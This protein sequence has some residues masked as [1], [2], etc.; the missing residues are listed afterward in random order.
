MIM[1][2]QGRYVR[3]QLHARWVYS[4]ANLWLDNLS[5]TRWLRFRG[6]AACLILP[7]SVVDSFGPEPIAVRISDRTRYPP[8]GLLVIISLHFLLEQAPDQFARSIGRRASC[9]L[10]W[11]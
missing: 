3:R 1:G 10:V 8:D 2:V 5:L 6:A 4:L 9:D 11:V 7:R